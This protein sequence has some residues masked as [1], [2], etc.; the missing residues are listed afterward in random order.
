[1]RNLLAA[2]YIVWPQLDGGGLAAYTDY[3][4]MCP[5]YRMISAASAPKNAHEDEGFMSADTTPPTATSTGSTPATPEKVF[6]TIP[7]AKPNQKYHAPK[8]YQQPA[9]RSL[10]T[11]LVILMAL[12]L[13]LVPA[14]LIIMIAYN[15]YASSPDLLWLWITMFVLVEAIAIFAAIGIAREAIGVTPRSDYEAAR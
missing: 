15:T 11:A 2:S 8:N 10:S 4:R 9:L 12:S 7:Q 14:I 1:M 6:V 5:R 3:L 13:P